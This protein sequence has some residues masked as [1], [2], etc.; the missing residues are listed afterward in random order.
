MKNTERWLRVEEL[1]HR[2]LE[3]AESRRAEFLKSACEGDEALRL[4][5]ESLLAQEKKAEHFIESPALEVVS[6]WIA[7]EAAL[8]SGEKLIGSKVSHYRVIEKLGGGGMGVVYKAEDMR[9]HRF[10][11]L[12]FLPETLA[13]EP[14]SLARFQREAQ[15]ASALNH[16][17]IC[18]IYDIGEHDGT[19]FIAME[20]LDGQTLKHIINGKALATDQ[21]IDIGVQIA[22]A[23]DAA[24]SNAIVHR[25]V[26][27]ANIFVTKRGQPKLLDFGLAK[28]SRQFPKVAQAPAAMDAPTIEAQLTETGVAI[29]TVA[30]MSPEQVR[31][32]DLDARTDIFSFGVVLYEMASGKQPFRGRTSGEICG[33]VLHVTPPSPS[34]LNPNLLPKL[35]EIIVKSLEKNRE[36]RYGH[37]ADLCTDLKRLKRE[38]ES[39]QTIRSKLGESRKTLVPPLEDKR[40]KWMLPITAA[41][42]VVSV[43]ITFFLKTHKPFTLGETDW[44]LISDFTNKTGD[45]IF[46]TSLKQAIAVHLSQSPFLNI[47]S[48]ARVNST[49]RLMTKPPT[50]KLSL[51]LA[52]DVCVRAGAK[53]IIAGSIA[54][55]GSEYVISL[56]AANCQTGDTIVQQQT[57]TESKEHVLQSLAQVADRMREKLGES[58]STIQ[59]FDVPI[60]EATTPSLDALEALSMGR[61]VQQQKGNAAAIPFF[62]RAIELD[63]NCAAA[64]A[65]LGTSYSN[66]REPGL[67]SENLRKAY[68]LRDKVS[69][70]EK[71]QFTAYYY[72]LV[73]G[74]LEKAN[75]TYELWAQIY[76]RDNV[77]RSNLG[78]T[79]GYLGE[80]DKAVTEIQQAIKLNPTSAV[81]FTNLVSHYTALGRLEDA[82]A[83]YE[84]AL[85]GKLDNPYLHLNRYAVAFLEGDSREMQQQIAW[86]SGSPQAENL[87]MSAASDTEAYYARLGSARE[88]SRRASESALRSDQKETAA[89]WQMNAALREAEFGNS[90][91]AR[92]QARSALHIARNDDLEILAALTFARAGDPENT[93]PIAD[94]LARRYPLD[95]ATNRYWLPSIRAAMAIAAHNPGAA[96][97]FLST[98]ISP[99]ELGNPLP[100]PEIGP[101]LYPIYLRGQAYLLLNRGTEASTEFQKFLDHR[102]LTVNC[103]LGALAHLGLARAYALMGSRDKSIARYREFLTLWKDADPD[104]P[105]LKQAKAEYA[106]LR[107]ERTQAAGVEVLLDALSSHF[108]DIATILVALAPRSQTIR[109]GIGLLSESQPLNLHLELACIC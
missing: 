63:P 102:G 25:D 75:E 61:K 10:V 11:A 23:L 106:K 46:D 13:H 69:Q 85:A 32:E 14:Q 53:A 91:R 45:S 89:E 65:A 52:R 103:P 97:G 92:E 105:I 4:E 64:Y 35:S 72:H 36:L 67:A 109:S 87:L 98:T 68:Q 86:A 16:P 39:G 48:D 17:N 20:F 19:A 60:E 70:R 58:L 94:N 42:I 96:I 51:E 26:K 9:L 81:G 66:L 95:T 29:G 74:E 50:T 5:I 55:I 107:S 104:I 57:T 99:Y 43:G 18:T 77:P 1:C 33:E 31:G 40:R 7:S 90:A 49:L 8:E 71:F 78:V 2:A 6:Q 80:Y 41:V 15:S 30:Y 88:L 101:C 12:K 28:L 21:I 73:T 47:L 79:Y 3:V 38:T 83:I 59:K 56:T 82:K 34:M 100:Q 54:R 93:Q 84:Q 62:Q 22:D 76:T 44:V 108:R 27:P 24:H 37:A